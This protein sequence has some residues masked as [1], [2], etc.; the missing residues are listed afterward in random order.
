MKRLLAVLLTVAM[1]FTA[2][3]AFAEE[4]DTTLNL[5]DIG[6]FSAGGTVTEPGGAPQVDSEQYNRLLEAKIPIIFYFGDYMENGPED[7]MS[8][9]FW[10]MI[11]AGAVSFA[12]AYIATR[13]FDAWLDTLK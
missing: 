5:A 3:T 9:G 1:L 7:I 10:S 12:E 4:A 6:M 8:S 2:L 11:K 13:E